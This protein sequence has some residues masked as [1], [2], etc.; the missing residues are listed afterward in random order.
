MS[1]TVTLFEAFARHLETHPDKLLYRYLLDGVPTGATSEW[2]YADAYGR[3]AAVA[4]LLSEHGLANKRALLLYP[5]S[6]D[7]VA[8]FLGC[9]M[10]RA[11]A[12]PAYPPDPSRLQQTLPRL[13]A[14]ANAAKIDVVLTTS[15]ISRIASMLV[16]GTALSQIPWVCTDDLSP[17]SGSER[18]LAAPDDHELAY[19]QF[20]SGSTSEPKGVMVTHTNVA[21][22]SVLIRDKFGATPDSHG[23]IWLPPYHDMGLV[24]GIIQ[25]LYV[26]FSSTLMSPIDFLKRPTKWIEAVS[27]FRG[28]IS[29]GPD[30]AY[31]LCARRF[32]PGEHEIDLSC[33]DIAFNGAEPIRA[34]T[35]AR[36]TQTFAPHG[37]SRRAF[38]PCYGLAEATLMVTGGDRTLTA[39]HCLADKDALTRGRF[40]PGSVADEAH[41][42]VS[43]GSPTDDHR[44]AVVDPQT[45]RRVEPGTVGE[46]WV[47]GP[48]VTAGYWDRPE[49]TRESFAVEISGESDA[50]VFMRT[51]D[52]GFVLDGELYVTGR[53]KDLII[54]RGRNHYPQDLESTA[55]SAHEAIRAGCVAAYSTDPGGEQGVGIAVEIRNSSSNSL[56]EIIRAVRAAIASTHALNVAEV[57]LLKARAMPKTSSGKLIRSACRAGVRDGS[58]VPVSR[59]CAGDRLDTLERDDPEVADQPRW[60]EHRLRAWL[61]EALSRHT[62]LSIDDID[63]RRPLAE[64]GL[65][66]QVSVQIAGE[67]ESTLGRPLAPTL[68][69]D[70]P[71]IDAIAAHLSEDP[72]RLAASGSST[73]AGKTPAPA[74]D[75]AIAIVA[76]GCRFPGGVNSPEDLWKLLLD[77]QD[78]I[79]TVPEL[80]WT[81]AHVRERDASS[82]ASGFGGFI[83]GVE[84]FDASFFHISPREAQSLDPQQRLLLE[85]S[86]EALERAGLATRALSGS[87]TGVFVGVSANDYSR[88]QD[89]AGAVDGRYFVTGNMNSVA[90]G[91]IAYTF[92]LA[93]PALAVDTACSSSLVAVHLACQSLRDGDCDRALA[94]GV[95]LILSPEANLY[96][97]QLNA[98]SASGRCAAFDSDAD[99]YVRSEGCAVLVLERLAD[100]RACNDPILGVIRGS[101]VTH[102]GR[103][104]GLTAPNG[105]SQEAVIRKALARA[106]VE[107][108][109]VSYVEAHGTGTPLGDPIELRSLDAVYGPDR[110]NDEP[111]L[112]GSAKSNIGHTEAVAGIAGLLKIVLAMA[113]EQ[114]PGNLHFRAPTPHFGWAD[115]ALRV[116][117]Q[118]TAWPAADAQP[119]IAGLSSFGFS[120]TNVHM[121]VEEA[122][123]R[124]ARARSDAAEL[125]QL[126]LIAA[127][128]RAALEA[129]IT[130]VCELLEQGDD[131][132]DRIA[133]L[134]FSLASAG[135]HL[136]QRVAAV[137]CSSAQLRTDLEARA[138]S[139]STARAEGKLAFL[140]TGQGALRPGMGRE[141]A[142]RWPICAEVLDSCD[143]VFRRQSGLPHGLREVMWASAEQPEAALLEQT[144]YG[145][146]ALLA[147][148][149]MLLE[150]WRELG[151][152]PELVVGHS[153]GEFAAAYCAGIMSLEDAMSLVVVRGRGMNRLPAGAMTSLRMGEDQARSL[154]RGRT[155]LTIAAV[156]GPKQVVI[157]GE[158]GPMDAL[159]R[160]LS[161]SG[162]KFRRLPVAHAFH[163]PLM[164][165]MIAEFEGHARTIRHSAPRIDFVSTVAGSKLADEPLCSN[166]WVDH[167]RAPV[168][169]SEALELARDGV[170]FFVEIGPCAVLSALAQTSL[171]D[172]RA[173]F[174]AC[175][176]EGKREDQTLLETLA[177]LYQRGFDFD[178][179]PLF[180]DERRRLRLPRYP[181]QHRSFWVDLPKPGPT[182]GSVTPPSTSTHRLVQRQLE[183]MNKQ[184][185]ILQARPKTAS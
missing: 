10:A 165:P 101:A 133:D 172:S 176:R 124:A 35:L 11:V 109:Q 161:T 75:D 106:G 131:G 69:W 14:I 151:V 135:A 120:G 169:F 61:R 80:R 39:A 13:L 155:G 15:G 48:S 52:L 140:F 153:V 96:F 147:F 46:I 4:E 24:G 79:S 117:A 36:F 32:Q 150:L 30:F 154:L 119:R 178:A 49:A 152:E 149:A 16:A 51:G 122:P 180:D 63:S 184:I 146:P 175:C 38:Y 112:V 107:P 162:V 121:V 59:W 25:P 95:N 138:I 185:R 141:L 45:C 62:G 7:Y 47:S 160:E 43:S 126:V 78:P 125:P 70:Y 171:V 83:D 29:G 104:N 84:Q 54:V 91:R 58:I 33:W 163:S 115:H 173:T 64:Y 82:P 42:L 77:G 55:A 6:L 8:T 108:R 19:L 111:L 86:W 157:A 21:H 129:R 40:S 105:P 181:W 145:Q 44:V 130:G 166:Y 17:S 167:I 53:L 156:N 85:V 183:L 34:D 9:L 90:A 132:N 177:G 89:K 100:A 81:E 128:S 26:G 99:G 142:Q 118:T 159:E 28:T 66:S 23:V 94:G 170:D 174:L 123:R 50:G 114:L 102:D 76:V 31:A 27:Q 168:R 98:L 139:R 1:K 143:R 60:P 144:Q 12:V 148:Q 88:R 20:T 71:T 56:D 97:D 137:A 73:S 179:G 116:V 103:S 134:S 65:D 67:L 158:L 136:P 110:R 68:V 93:G 3:S 2:S 41:E 57:L 127:H 87:S 164:E 72:P 22:N 92:G 18:W 37:F 113:A 5:P 74:R 182:R